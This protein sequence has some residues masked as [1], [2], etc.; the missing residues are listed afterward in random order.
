[1]TL[2]RTTA[3]RIARSG[4]LVPLA[5][6]AGPFTLAGYRR[7]GTMRGD[8]LI[9]Y[10]EGDGNAWINR[11]RLA[12]DPTPSD[13]LALRLAAADDA[14]NVVYLARPCQY[15]S[16]SAARH[17]H[18]RYWSTARFA[19]EV[20]DGTSRAIDRVKA[21]AGTRRIELIGYSGGGVLATL[22]AARRDDVSLVITVGA[23]LDVSAWTTHHRVTPLY[24]SLNP[25]DF[26]ARLTAV[27]QVIFV[28]GEDD[29]VPRAISERYRN[30]FPPG[31]PV[32]MIQRARF[33]HGCCW[34]EHWRELLG[35]ARGSAIKH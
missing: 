27:P 33:S 28:G 8:T 19:A 18:P 21:D 23:N 25:I 6:D 2:L 29:I 7:A 24:E 30:A 16:G 10:I 20:V 17:C 1:M 32:R 26:V 31:A 15:V 22:L 34:V 11:G 14:P 5:L 9:V 35:E 3:D 13:P 4:Q 12:E